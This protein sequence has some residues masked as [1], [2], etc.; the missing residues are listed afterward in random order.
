[1]KTI[2]KINGGHLKDKWLMLGLIVYF[3]QIILNSSTSLKHSFIRSNTVEVR[4]KQINTD[5]TLCYFCRKP[6]SFLRCIDFTSS[7]LHVGHHHL[8]FLM[9]LSIH[10]LRLRLINDKWFKILILSCYLHFAFISL[11]VCRHAELDSS[12]TDLSCLL[13]DGLSS[14][15]VWA[16]VKSTWMPFW[17][18]LEFWHLSARS[19]QK[20]K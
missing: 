8:V 4:V 7:Q 11:P 3:D 15:A 12:T 10:N 14:S 2:C 9:L 13:S 19:Y 5:Q 1:M 16:K 6:L 18:L 20:Q 17:C